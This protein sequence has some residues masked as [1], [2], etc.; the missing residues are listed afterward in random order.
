MT[1]EI[2]E[3][4]RQFLAYIKAHRHIGYGRMMQIIGNVWYRMLERE[5]PGLE[6]GAFAGQTCFALLSEQEQRTILALL[7]QEEQQGMEY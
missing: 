2:F 3:E 5:Y 6:G 4:E 7:E 1:F